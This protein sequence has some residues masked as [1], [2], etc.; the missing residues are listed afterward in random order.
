M[1][2]ALFINCKITIFN[3]KILW[4]YG[5]GLR[6]GAQNPLWIRN[7]TGI[8]NKPMMCMISVWNQN[9]KYDK[10]LT[11]GSCYCFTNKGGANV[12]TTFGRFR[13]QTVRV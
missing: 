4:G 8:H 6:R 13:L 1:N 10:S 11:I 7:G 12:I 9:T 5:M 3:D 2:M